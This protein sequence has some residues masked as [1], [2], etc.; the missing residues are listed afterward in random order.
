MSLG[1]KVV[2]ARKSKGLTQ[3]QLA[4]RATITVRT[5][6]RIESDESIPRDYTLKAIASALNMP[7]EEF[8]PVRSCLR[9]INL[10][11]HLQDHQPIRRDENCHFLQLLNLS[12]FAYLVVPFI[13]FLIPI[14]L[15]KKRK[16]KDDTLQTTGQRI[17]RQQ[18]YW[19]VCTHFLLF[20]TLVYNLIQATWFDKSN[21]LN[22]IWIFAAMYILNALIIGTTALKIRNYNRASYIRG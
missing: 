9:N 17:I 6:Q 7:F 14:L 16:E 21:L 3:E 4:E 12:A 13:H 18:I 5:I 19:T 10:S 11:S 15:L 22:Y 8:I 20:L 1:H 2:S